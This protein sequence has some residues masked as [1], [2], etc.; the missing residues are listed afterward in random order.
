[1]A[2]ETSTFLERQ[3]DK[4]VPGLLENEATSALLISLLWVLVIFLFLC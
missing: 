3:Q 1:M 2:V 4:V